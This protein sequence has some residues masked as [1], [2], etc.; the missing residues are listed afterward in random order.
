MM[1]ETGHTNRRVQE[2][3]IKE[4]M[5]LMSFML[6]KRMNHHQTKSKVTAVS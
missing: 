6:H 5:L 2:E 4:I 1:K 3:G